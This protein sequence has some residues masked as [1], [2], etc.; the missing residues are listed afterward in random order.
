M[1]LYCPAV[2]I[3]KW[4]LFTYVM[5]TT[6]HNSCRFHLMFIMSL[7]RSITCGLYTIKQAHALNWVTADT[8]CPPLHGMTTSWNV[9]VDLNGHQILSFGI[10][11][12][13]LYII[14]WL[15]TNF[16]RINDLTFTS[17]LNS[18]AAM[19]SI[20]IAT[21]QLEDYGWCNRVV[22]RPPFCVLKCFLQN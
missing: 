20:V 19:T 16:I 12:T 13:L 4:P 5:C 18:C 9:C 2:T 1:L 3:K 15:N 17:C 7:L 6:L 11:F 10:C 8:I 22:M 21:D 14:P